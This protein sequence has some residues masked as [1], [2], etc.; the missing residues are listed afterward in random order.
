MVLLRVIVMQMS[1]AAVKKGKWDFF[2]VV[3]DHCTR[4]LFSV[5]TDLLYKQIDNSKIAGV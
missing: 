1:L 2:V 3:V 4:L 5:N